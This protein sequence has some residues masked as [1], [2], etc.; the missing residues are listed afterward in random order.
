M[1]FNYLKTAWRNLW[2]DKFYSGLNM[3]GLAIGLGTGI[4]I[5]LWIKKMS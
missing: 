5:L 4:M 2:K 1:I 3:L